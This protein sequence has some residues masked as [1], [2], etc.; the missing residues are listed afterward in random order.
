MKIILVGYPESQHIVPASQYLVNKYLPDFDV[1]YLNNEGDTKN[2]SKNLSV[3]FSQLEDEFVIF[4]LDD[5][6]LNSPM[7]MKVYNELFERINLN[8]D[9]ACAK[10]C[11]NT[12]QEHEEYPV[13]TQ[14]MIWRRT[15]LIWFLDQT[16]DPWGF[17]IHGSNIMRYSGKRSVYND[18]P[19][20]DYPVHSCLSKRWEGVRTDGVNQED[21]EYLK[22]NNLL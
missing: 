13:T 15:D 12:S 19:A 17:E 18:P 14:Y 4:A 10:L 2:W 8:K 9:I 16:T 20:L 3:F 6:L 1:I 5:Y 7:D 21:L 22:N 11:K